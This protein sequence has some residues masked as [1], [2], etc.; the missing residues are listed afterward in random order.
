[1]EC[2]AR[3]ATR[4][5]SRQSGLRRRFAPEPAHR[6]ARPAENADAKRNAFAHGVCR[7]TGFRLN[8][9]LLRTVIEQADADMIEA[10]ILLDFSHDL[11][12]HV[13]RVVARDCGAGNIVEK[14]Q[15]PRAPLF[16]R[17]GAHS[18]PQPIPAGSGHQHVQVALLKTN[19][20]S[21]LMATITPP[22][23]P[24]QDGRGA[25]TLGGMLGAESNT[26]AGP[27]L[28]QVGAY[29][30]WLSG[31]NHVFGEGVLQ[32]AS[33]LGQDTII[34]HFQLEA[35]FVAYPGMR[36]RNCCY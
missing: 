35:D 28:L 22:A 27:R 6:S 23:C 17:E 32:F 21:V 8:F 4:A 12:Q 1:M 10:E 20:R 33:S 34:L 14:R 19:S 15:L 29:Q 3:S 36:C 25:K 9:D 26:Q 31:P 30:Q 5:R 2:R 18:P 24:Q 16:F 13:N 7:C 11:A